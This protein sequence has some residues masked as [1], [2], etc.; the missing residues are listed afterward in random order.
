MVAS[1][2]THDEDISAFEPLLC[3]PIEIVRES[4][5]PC[6]ECIEKRK[7]ETIVREG[8]ITTLVGRIERARG[9]QE[10]ARQVKR[11]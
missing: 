7:R 10:S 9:K 3:D 5:A 1:S 8:L 6:Y 4:T 11:K 2:F